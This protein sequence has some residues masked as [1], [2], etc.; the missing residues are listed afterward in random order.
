MVKVFLSLL[1]YVTLFAN[2]DAN[3]TSQPH[4]SA[5]DAKIKTFLDNK[6]YQDNKKYIKIIFSPEQSFYNNDH[7]DVVKV[8]NTLKDNGLL[9]LFF[10]KPR[11]FKLS[12]ITSGSPLFFVKIMKESLR[13]IGYYRYVT[14]SSKLDNSE[15][16]WD[17]VLTSEYATDPTIL[18]KELAK[19]GCKI[20]DIK[21]ESPT[22][23]TYVIDM[24]KA[25]LN[26]TKLS[27][28]LEVELTR[29]L[30]AHWLDVSSVSKLRIVSSFR[31]SW[32]PYIAFYDN[33]LH[34]LKVI[35]KDSKTRYLNLTIPKNAT[36]MKVSDMYS[37]KNIKDT[38][39]LIP[40]EVR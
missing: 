32:Y 22:K 10:K 7:I 21:R 29:S 4:L 37:L 5:L 12:F 23:W 6:S 27:S 3:I 19:D 30:Y 36:Y 1:F 38:L 25:F 28:G 17:I 18:Q 35:R 31:N 13:D 14:V 26:L 20:L 2:E 15:F 34:L 8:V 40:S 9:K 24:N 39:T 11:E 33:S 16:R